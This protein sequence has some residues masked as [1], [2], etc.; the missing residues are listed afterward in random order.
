M[1]YLVLG[2]GGTG[3]ALGA[4]LARGGCDV[5]LIARG[6]QLRALRERG[7]EVAKPGERFTVRPEAWDTETYSGSPDAVF[8]CVKGYSLAETVPFLRR[9]CRRDTVVI[10]ILNLP[11]TGRQLQALLPDTPVLDGCIYIAS[12]LSAPGQIL[13]RGSILRVF[14]GPRSPEDMHPELEEIRADLQRSGVD[15]VLSRD[16]RRDC[17]RKFSY[18]SPQGACGLYYGVSAGAMQKPGEARDCFAALAAEIGLLASA[19]GA[20]LGG[21]LVSRNLHILDGVEPE[22]TTSLQRDVLRGGP[23]ELAG[24]VLDVPGLGRR[25]GVPLPAY[26]KIAAALRAKERSTHD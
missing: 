18:V 7:L 19:M 2:A 10:P 3:G 20:D 17:L 26:E 21:D 14:F 15:G 5:S 24:L 22:M 13:M 12:E 25:H 23:S 16:I 4:H 8:L 1:K 11:E 9:I 6:A